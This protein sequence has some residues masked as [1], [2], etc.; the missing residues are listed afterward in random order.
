MLALWLTLALA[1]ARGDARKLQA[2]ERWEEAAG[3]CRSELA[4]HPDKEWAL[5]CLADATQAQVDA[6]VAYARARADGENL[7]GALGS[8]E[9]ARRVQRQ[10]RTG[11]VE[12]AVPDGL[13]RELRQRAA[14]PSLAAAEAA[15]AEGRWAEAATAL[16]NGLALVASV[17]RAPLEGRLAEA[18]RRQA[19]SA[20]LPV[21][22]AL[23][24]EVVGITGL[25]A[26]RG[27]AAMAWRSLGQEQ[28]ARGD[29]R[30]ATEALS[31]AVVY[32]PSLEPERDRVE[33]LARTDIVLRVTAAD[34]VVARALQE[35]LEAALRTRGS[36][37]VRV[38]TRGGE[39]RVVPGSEGPE[40]VGPG[41]VLVRVGSLSVAKGEPSYRRVTR[42]EGAVTK[43]VE[44]GSLV[45]Q[46]AL[47]LDVAIEVGE[48]SIRQHLSEEAAETARW[49][50][51]VKAVRT[52]AGTKHVGGER[53]GDR[54][55][56]ATEAK[57]RAEAAAITRLASTV[58]AE[59]LRQVDQADPRLP[60]QEATAP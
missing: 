19:A 50:G 22:A 2:Q 59:V 16:R 52:P 9:D 48:R 47:D 60:P 8:L 41:Q 24:E 23:L 56:A 27:H 21:R 39:E 36:R 40:R 13:E 12:V 54:G 30:G 18:L 38:R 1:G 4:I 14:T 26:D 57:Q 17:D 35:G 6:A 7:P 49:D 53:S 37:F 15:E 43:V 5:R 51:K 32:D 58:A 3:V 10:A 25:D 29:V 33:R 31:R 45:V 55:P 28:E 11:G 46:V 44:E 20:P 42:P 34:P